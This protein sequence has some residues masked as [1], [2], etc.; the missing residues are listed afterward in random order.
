MLRQA[1]PVVALAVAAVHPVAGRSAPAA[2][3]HGL[4]PMPGVT[5]IGT[6][7][8]GIS[9][10]GSTVVGYG[11][12]NP[13]ATHA[14]RWTQSEGYDVIGGG[15]DSR[16]L[17][18]SFDGSV[19]VGQANLRAFRWTRDTGMEELPIYHAL[20]VSADGQAI[21]GMN[22]R[23]MSPNLY[24]DL[25]VL[26]GGDYTSAYG[27]SADGQV[28]VGFAE[29]APHRHAHAF[30]WTAAGGIRD[31]GVTTGIE[32]VAWGVSGDGH[33]VVGEAR[34]APGFW[35]A[36]RWTSGLG[37]RDLGTLG[38]PMS[39]AHGTSRD[40]RIIVGKSLVNSVTTS[41]RAFRWTPEGGMRDVRQLLLEAGV[42]AVQHWILSVAVDVSD[43]GTAI[44][45]WGFSP[46]QI[47]EPWI[48]VLPPEG[49]R[50]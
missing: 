39:T 10:D 16:A 37:M 6:Y 20:D 21:A 47:W 46:R 41:L 34:S 5:P 35:R 48:A 12:V 11:W 25:G 3:F 29:T 23:W 4:G 31:L 2:A 27:I 43:D 45:G 50:R 8:S 32:S 28:V 49:S 38:G 42:A 7:A 30:R 19:I 26:R 9:G 14:F 40:G 18:S 13:H 17:A 22:I 15:T 36:F 24:T 1:I 33:V 44:A